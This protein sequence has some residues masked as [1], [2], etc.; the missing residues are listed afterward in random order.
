MEPKSIDRI[1]WDAAQL[2]SLEERDAYLEQACG[3]DAPLRRRVEQFLQARSKA[4][5][6]LESPPPVLAATVDEPLTERPGTVIG[7]Y[8]LL[9]QIGEGGFGVVFMA[10]Q[11]QPLRRKV[12]LKVVKPGMDSKQVIARFEAERQALA[13]MDHPNI[14]HVLDAGTT[15]TGRPYFVMELVKGIPITQFC[16][17]SR[18]T[19]QER[20]RLFISVCGAV[21]HAHQKGVIHRDLKPSNVLVTLHDGTPVPKVIDFGIAKAVGQQ[22]TDKTL[23]T[24]FAQMVGTP[25]YMSPEQAALSGLDV[26]T[27]SDV[28]ALGVLLYEL[29]TGTT[30][31]DA[32]ALR[33]A[34][35]DEMRRII[36]ED[37]PP[38]PSTRLSTLEKAS[39][40]TVAE[41]RGVEPHKLGQQVRGELDWIV[42]RALEKDRQQRYESASAFAADVERY[43]EGEPVHACPPSAGY[44]LKKFARRNKVALA[45]AGLVAAAL[46]IGTTVSIWQAIEANRARQIADK[47]RQRAED[48]FALARRAVD[49][50]YTEVAQKWLDEQVRMT[51]VQRQFLEKALRFYQGFAQQAGKEPTV[52]LEAAR[53]YKRVG[54][55]QGKLGAYPDAETAYR[56]ALHILEP[57]AANFPTLPQ[58]GQ[59]LASICNTLGGLLDKT[60]R[61]AQAEQA[62]RQ[63][64][65]L[66]E[67]LVAEFPTVA[68]YR[69]DLASSHQSLGGLFFDKLHRFPDAEKAFEQARTIWQKLAADFP[70]APDYRGSL[71]TTQRCLA[72]L[73]EHDGRVKEAV[74]AER[75]ALEVWERLAAEFPTRPRYRAECTNA[76]EWLGWALYSDEQY[77]EG[78]AACQQALK[79]REKLVAD[80]PSVVDYRL[81]LAQSYYM[82]S[83]RHNLPEREKNARQALAVC[84]KLVA[85]FPSVP[86]GRWGLVM[87]HRYLAETFAETPTEKEKHYSQAIAI[88]EKLV[89]DFPSEPSYRVELA[90]N[91]C[92]FGL[93]LHEMG[94][95]SEAETAFQRSATLCEKLATDAP[96][97]PEYRDNWTHGLFNLGMVR[98]D[99]ARYDEAERLLRQ[100]QVILEK[101]VS[102]VPKNATYQRDLSDTLSLLANLCRDRG[103]LAEAR[104]LFG[105]AIAC[106]KKAL[107][108]SGK[109]SPDIQ[110]GVGS[111][112]LELAV[113]LLQMRQDPALTDQIEELIREG[114]RC[115]GDHPAAQTDLAWFLATCPEPRFRDP[116]RAVELGKRLVEQ[117]RYKPAR[118]RALGA[119]LYRK[120]DGQGSVTALEKAME[121]SNGGKGTER[122]FRAMATWQMGNKQQAR[123]LYEDA[124][125]WMAK[126]KPHDYDLRR[127]RAEAAALLGIPEEPLNKQSANNKLPGGD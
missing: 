86:E 51:E 23:F 107:E 24:G 47:Q 125:Q 120:G 44:R 4:E 75:K 111:F 92:N 12:A 19:T 65:G 62:L 29:L 88:A 104:R 95:L 106:R 109:T 25:L 117:G 84:E 99:M 21:Q 16:D 93:L 56:D 61:P 28:Y 8:K 63:A 89:N 66:R 17:Q 32:E 41:H 59:Q 64:L 14:A 43:L 96:A 122:F 87:N 80:F 71:A 35:Y 52:Q 9:E 49:E 60:G 46:L 69:A 105:E 11:Q 74:R 108:L 31:F 72:V 91:H 33:R 90:A 81:Q 48:N 38:K 58:Y 34:G 10:E 85:D 82:L 2:R 39:L 70:N 101:L 68:Q 13:L 1:F 7:P 53:A 124:V 115:S 22:L 113:T 127:F 77:A 116:E 37:E 27:R 83:W 110:G 121:L 98:R 78:L 118:W 40:S 3:G 73:L 42:M 50:M 26:D 100:A 76:Y 103:N 94:R 114:T 119:A 102:E 112:C 55:I 5:N 54:D 18:L 30:P 15:D 67:K 97:Q 57:L 126:H 6:F 79:L 45:T 36:R 20:L 123:A